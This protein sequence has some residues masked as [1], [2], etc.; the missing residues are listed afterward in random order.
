M[1]IPGNMT[2]AKIFPGFILLVAW[3]NYKC[4]QTYNL[5]IEK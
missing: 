2:L 4:S 5:D 3:I 1:N